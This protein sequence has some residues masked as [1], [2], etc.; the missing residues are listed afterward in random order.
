[1]TTT[2]KP[3]SLIVA[4]TQNGGIGMNNGIPWHVPQDMKHFYRVTTGTTGTSVT[5][6]NA[7][8]MG[9]KTWESMQQKRLKNRINVVISG[10]QTLTDEYAKSHDIILAKSLQDALDKLR[11]IGDVVIGDV[12]VIGGASVYQDALCHPMCTTA[13]VT[14]IHGHYDCD[15]FFPVEALA[16]TFEKDGTVTCLYVEETPVYSIVK[17]ERR[18]L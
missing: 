9:R 18:K 13:H 11:E 1:M 4:C 3:F 8:I 5:N 2:T 10:S 16:R 7:V 6:M 12:F 15:T 14:W 17:Y